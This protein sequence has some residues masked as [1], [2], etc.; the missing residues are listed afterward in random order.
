MAED[1]EAR[2]RR[3]I[4]SAHDA[5]EDSKELSRLS[6]AGGRKFGDSFYLGIE[7]GL[8]EALIHFH[9]AARTARTPAVSSGMM[10]R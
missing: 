5:W 8:R 7:A 9:A 4:Q 1:F 3:S 10:R 2:V 6:N